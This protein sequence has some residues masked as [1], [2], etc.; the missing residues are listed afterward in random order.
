[1]G[2]GITVSLSYKVTGDTTTTAAVNWGTA[3]ESSN[4]N[5][6]QS[7]GRSHVATVTAGTNHFTLQAASSSTN[8]GSTLSYP[9][10]IAI[11][12]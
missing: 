6:F 7:V 9:Y 3:D 11:P 12:L 1:V 10:I 2:A 8:D 4:A 5:D